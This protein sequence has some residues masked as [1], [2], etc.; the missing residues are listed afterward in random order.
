L[1]SARDTLSANAGAPRSAHIYAAEHKSTINA[2]MHFNS[3]GIL[4]EEQNPLLSGSGNWIAAALNLRA[5]LESSSFCEAILRDHRLSD[6]ASFQVSGLRSGREF[7]R[8][9]L[10]ITVRALNDAELLYDARCQPHGEED[11]TLHV[12]VNPYTND[13][14]IA[15]QLEK[16]FRACLRWSCHNE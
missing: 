1:L 7:Q 3:S 13:E 4:Y 14:E 5:A 12:T 11:I 16:L 2:P 8:T 10:C 9:Y 6:W 15:R